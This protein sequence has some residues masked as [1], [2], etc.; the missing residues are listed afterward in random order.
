MRDLKHDAAVSA[1]RLIRDGQIVGLG[2]GSTVSYLIR[3]LSQR[4]KEEELQLLCIPTSKGTEALAQQAGIPLTTFEEHLDID[5]AIDGADQVSEAL[6]LIKGG[7][8]AHTREKIVATCARRFLIIVDESKLSEK[9]NIPV[10]VEV[11]PFSWK[12]SSEFLTAKGGKPSLRGSPEKVGP[13]I[14]DNGN[15]ILD[16]DFGEIRD[17]ENLEAR[18]NSVIGVVE[19][20]VFPGM[21]HE[22][23]VGTADGVKILRRK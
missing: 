3:E 10:P 5:I 22:V 20:G 19:N 23:H 9:L 17:P 4:I 7:G 15:Y 18:I 12:V 21:A 6:D 1:C 2:T 16:V 11:L 8:A 13:T 14:T